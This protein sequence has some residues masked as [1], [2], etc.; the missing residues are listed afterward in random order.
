MSEQEFRENILQRLAA[1]EVEMKSFRE[2]LTALRN[3]AIGVLV[4]VVGGVLTY[5]VIH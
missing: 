1:I 2:S 4:T 5:S 3:A